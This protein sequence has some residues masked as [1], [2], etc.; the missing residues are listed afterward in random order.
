MTKQQSLIVKPHKIVIEDYY[1][2]SYN[3]FV[4]LRT[5]LLVIMFFFC[6]NICSMIT[7]EMFVIEPFD[8]TDFV[9]SWISYLILIII[10]LIVSSIFIVFKS[11]QEKVKNALFPCA[12]SDDIILGYLLSNTL[13]FKVT[14]LL[15]L[16][17]TVS[18]SYY[19]YFIARYINNHLDNVDDNKQNIE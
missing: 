1:N 15:L 13:F 9:Y 16:K 2:L 4:A 11:L 12:S 10:E 8:E 7:F 18:W 3:N 14:Y 17:F 5:S 6:L 19:P